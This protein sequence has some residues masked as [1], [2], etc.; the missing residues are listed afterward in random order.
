[1]KRWLFRFNLANS[2]LEVNFKITIRFLISW[3][4][5]VSAAGISGSKPRWGH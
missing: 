1:M 2:E 4:S 5:E 3:Q